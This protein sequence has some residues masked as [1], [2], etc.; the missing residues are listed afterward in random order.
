L[1]FILLRSILQ[2]KRERGK[3]NA[4]KNVHPHILSRG[5]YDKLKANLMEERMKQMLE[6]GSSLI[7]LPTVL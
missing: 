2:E 6:E 4:S 5:G 7:D 1:N 3:K